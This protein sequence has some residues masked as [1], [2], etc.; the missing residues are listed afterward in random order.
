LLDLL[1]TTDQADPAGVVVDPVPFTDY[2]NLMYQAAA[3]GEKSSIGWVQMGG[4]GG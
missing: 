1:V 4:M 3:I 2:P